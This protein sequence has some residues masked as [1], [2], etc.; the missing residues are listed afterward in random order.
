MVLKD[1]L[2]EFACLGA[3]VLLGI[4]FFGL[5]LAAKPFPIILHPDTED[6]AQIARHFSNER[7]W[8]TSFMPLNGLDYLEQAHRSGLDWPSFTRFP[9][10]PFVFALMFQ[11]FG[12]SNWV[13][14]V[15]SG[16]FWVAGIP[17]V[18]VLAKRMFSI[19][20]A[21]ISVALYI[22]SPNLR[23]YA[24]TGL[25]EPASA[26][27]LVAMLVAIFKSESW[28]SAALGGMSLGLGYLNRNNFAIFLIPV[29]LYIAWVSNPRR[30]GFFVLGFVPFFVIGAWYNFLVSGDPTF[31]L[32]LSSTLPLRFYTGVLGWYDLSYLSPFV[33]ISQHL[34]FFA[35]KSISQLNILVNQILPA[36]AISPY[37]FALVLLAFFRQYPPAI[38][39]LRVLVLVLFASHAALVSVLAAAYDRMYVFFEPIAVVFVAGLVVEIA[40]R[41][42]PRFAP[43]ARFGIVVAAFGAVLV[44]GIRE[45]RTA[46][47]QPS[48]VAFAGVEINVANLAYVQQRVG[49]DQIVASDLPW[50]VAW[51]IDRRAIPLPP[52]PDMIQEVEKRFGLTV[53]AIYIKSEGVRF[54][55]Q[56]PTWDQWRALGKRDGELPGYFLDKVFPDGSV[57]FVKQ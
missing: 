13:L 18:Y 15:A 55:D 53:G 52:R 43:A 25:T 26:F 28:Q 1:R 7:V 8:I 36:L 57:L 2:L 11:M 29:L 16:L 41:L 50:S 56:P 39:R 51:R 34:D 20:A 45:E 37:I 23:S 38:H 54:A 27:F 44:F 42:V 19:Y 4:L 24:P 12:V 5:T 31:N 30:A 17:L 10:M 9:L 14:A 47:E 3:L 21:M 35:R 32:Q 33:Y 22:A 40:E 48:H 46:V 49:A 6:M